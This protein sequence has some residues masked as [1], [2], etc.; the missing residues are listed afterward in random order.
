MESIVPLSAAT[1]AGWS[2]AREYRSLRR[3]F[4]FGEFKNTWISGPFSTIDR[5]LERRVSSARSPLH[6]VWFATLLRSRSCDFRRLCFL[7]GLPPFRRL[8]C[9]DGFLGCLAHLLQ[10]RHWRLWVPCSLTVR[11]QS[12]LGFERRIPERRHTRVGEGKT[13][14]CLLAALRHPPLSFATHLAF[15]YCVAWLSATLSCDHLSRFFLRSNPM[16][17]AP[18]Q[19]C[20]HPVTNNRFKAETPRN[21]YLGRRPKPRD[22]GSP[23]EL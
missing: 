4:R 13:L 16:P 3:T 18:R 2:F 8:F 9:P 20:A 21:S 14:R 23:V 22:V 5:F 12:N 15:K 11:C 17:P 7:F 19:P 6:T 10:L 1:L